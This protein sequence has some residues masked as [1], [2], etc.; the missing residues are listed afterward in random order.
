MLARSV[1]YSLT[2]KSQDMTTGDPSSEDVGS[3]LWEAVRADTP[4]LCD[5]PGEG[6]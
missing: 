2:R 3:V 6:R 1:L 4:G 5:F